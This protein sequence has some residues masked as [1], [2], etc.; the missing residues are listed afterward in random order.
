MNIIIYKLH[1]CAKLVT[2]GEKLCVSHIHAQ[3]I[4]MSVHMIT[5]CK[6]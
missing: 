3:L 4:T 1:I 6:T 2:F 5:Q